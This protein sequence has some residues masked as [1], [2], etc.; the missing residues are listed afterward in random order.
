[1]ESSQETAVIQEALVPSQEKED[2]SADADLDLNPPIVGQ[3]TLH[4][5]TSAPK[6][7]EPQPLP[8]LSQDDDFL[9]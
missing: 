6:L 1:M 2:Q 3:G 9:R 8:V 5:E 7:P 4:L